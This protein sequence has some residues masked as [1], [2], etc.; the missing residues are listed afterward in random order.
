MSNLASKSLEIF[1]GTGGV[2]KT[3]LATSRA[4][5]LAKSKKV[6]LITIDPAK[7]LKQVLGIKEDHQGVQKVELSSFN[8]GATGDFDVLLM[9]P[10][11]TFRYIQH[12]LEKRELNFIL[13]QLLGAYG[14]LNE[15]MSIIEL[16]RHLESGNYDTVIL[17][18]PPGKN[19]VDFLKASQK[20]QSFFRPQFVKIISQLKDQSTKKSPRF[21]KQLV[22]SGIESLLKYLTRVTGEE[23]IANFVEALQDVYELTP[24][25]Q[26]AIQFQQ[27]IEKSDQVN[28][29]LVTSTDQGK[30]EAAISLYNKSIDF[31]P[32]GHSI[33][34]NKSLNIEISKDCDQQT[35]NFLNSL[36][37]R[38]NQLS[39]ELKTHFSSIHAFSEVISSEPQKHVISLAK[40]WKDKESNIN[41]Q[42]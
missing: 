16:N 12:A 30:I 35:L 33:L 5:H 26:K 37:Q 1:S 19:F 36:A 42:I 14:G 39:R 25:F 11:D 24:E 38:Q 27:K 40:Q 17:D 32:S 9:N 29:F 4:V 21:L 28:W 18:T 8:P 31:L 2:G 15:I 3:T 34:V 7:R 23:F 22:Q 13:K 10:L 6:L 20:I 41:E